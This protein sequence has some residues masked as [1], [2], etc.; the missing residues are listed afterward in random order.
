MKRSSSQELLDNGSKI[1]HQ[2]KPSKLSDTEEKIISQNA[3]STIILRVNDLRVNKKVIISCSSVFTSA[4][5]ITPRL[6]N[7][8]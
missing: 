4:P 8:K 7:L 3:L 2:P 6:V 5:I 1:E